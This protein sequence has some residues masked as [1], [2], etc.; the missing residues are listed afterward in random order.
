MHR[1]RRLLPV[2]AFAL[3]A[4][5][6]S[7]CTGAGAQTLPSVQVQVGQGQ[8]DQL[9]LGVQ[10]LLLLTVLSLVPAVL[11]MMTSFVRIA[12]V[13][14]FARSAIGMPQMPPNQ[15]LLGLSLFLT[16]IV[17]TPVWTALNDSAVQPYLR[18]EMTL[19]QAYTTGAGPLREFM[20]KQTREKDL[21]LFVSLSKLPQ[22]NTADD[23]PPQVVIPAFMISELKTAFQ[24]GFVIL[25][26]FLVIDMVVSSTLMAMGMMM[27]PPATN[28]LP[29]KVLLFGLADGWHLIIQSLVSSFS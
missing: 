8:G 4:A 3:V 20:L 7:G 13:L 11:M 2:P 29:F 23:L 9:T 14:S 19:E 17:M 12:I 16:V 15:I 28:S 10:L 6:L 1:L 21:A 27:L 22:P 26:P 18:G 25:L 24:M 5:A